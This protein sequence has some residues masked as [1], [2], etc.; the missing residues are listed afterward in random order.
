MNFGTIFVF[1]AVVVLGFAVFYGIKR[2]WIK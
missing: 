2:G 1:A